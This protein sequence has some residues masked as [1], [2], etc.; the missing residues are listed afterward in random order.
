MQAPEDRVQAGTSR[1]IWWL[2]LVIGGVGPA[3]GIGTCLYDATKYSRKATIHWNA[4]LAREQGGL[5]AGAP[6]SIAG[7]ISSDGRKSTG[8]LVI[9][10]ERQ[11]LYDNC[12]GT[13]V[14]LWEQRVENGFAYRLHYTTMLQRRSG[15]HVFVHTPQRRGHVDF[16][17]D[18]QGRARKYELEVE[19]LS[20]PRRGEALLTDTPP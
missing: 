14:D 18:A 9:S 10:C 8:C 17:T 11:V 15:P 1:K 19:E 5:R 6:C 20:L 12:A 2:L 7:R 16:G 13:S 4:R 3:V